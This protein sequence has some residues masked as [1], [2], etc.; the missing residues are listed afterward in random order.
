MVAR[1]PAPNTK[2][3]RDI[4]DA[5]YLSCFLHILP[6]I[7]PDKE[8]NPRENAEIMRNKNFDV[9]KELYESVYGEELSY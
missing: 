8:K 4:S 1:P 5:K 2:Q 3:K 9:W 7:Y 6:A